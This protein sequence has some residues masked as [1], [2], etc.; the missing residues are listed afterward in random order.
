MLQSGLCSVKLNTARLE[1]PENMF[2]RSTLITLIAA[3]FT[4]AGP[5]FAD[6]KGKGPTHTAPA[7]LPQH[8]QTLQSAPQLAGGP[9]CCGHTHTQAP[10]KTYTRTPVAP[11]EQI[12]TI[13]TSSF[14]G[15]VGVGV[16]DVFVGGGG[17]FGAGSSFGARSRGASVA[18]NVALSRSLSGRRGV[19]RG[20]G[21]R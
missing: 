15:G 7:P 14:T 12:M 19:R 20:G 18:R 2:T 16:N 11:A 1:A 17:F 3:S 9:S 10:L 13:D 5:A 6:G 8:T 4:L 21:I